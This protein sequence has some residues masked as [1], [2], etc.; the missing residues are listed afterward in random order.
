MKHLNV[1]T[2]ERP[3]VAAE[4][5]P[6]QLKDLVGDNTGLA[7]G[8]VILPR[9]PLGNMEG[10]QVRWLTAQWDNWLQK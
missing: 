10:D 1:L 6:I 3:A 9:D 7:K 4:F 8:G 2:A 5:A